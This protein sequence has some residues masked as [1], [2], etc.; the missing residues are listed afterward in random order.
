MFSERSRAQN[1]AVAE[2]PLP[3]DADLLDRLTP[4]ELA[5]G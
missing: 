4:Q 3:E 2:A 1:L 5:E